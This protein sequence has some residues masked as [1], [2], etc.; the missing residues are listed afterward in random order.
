MAASKDKYFS[1]L[2]LRLKHIPK[3]AL[4]V[5]VIGDERHLDEAK[6]SGIDCKSMDEL[7]KLNKDKKLVKK[8]GGCLVIFVSSVLNSF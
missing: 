7:K 4:K 8:M 2:F 5:C 6:A 3:P 1:N